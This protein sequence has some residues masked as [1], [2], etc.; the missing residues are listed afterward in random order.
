MS[1][2]P[3]SGSA[4]TWAASKPFIDS[5]ISLKFN[6]STLRL[7]LVHSILSFSYSTY[8][9][10]YLSIIIPESETACTSFVNDEGENAAIV[11]AIKIKAKNNVIVFVAK[12]DL[13]NIHNNVL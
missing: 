10:L 6:P 12:F 2:N 7:K 13:F 4:Y 9:D 8:F 3:T 11:S 1:V 5:G